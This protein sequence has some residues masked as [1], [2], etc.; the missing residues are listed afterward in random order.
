MDSHLR[1]VLADGFIPQASGQ[2]REVDGDLAWM[3]QTHPYPE[4]ARRELERA[5][6][7]IRDARLCLVAAR[8][9]TLEH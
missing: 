9:R 8:D 1:G 5:R 4:P 7:L 3:V 6:E 2:L